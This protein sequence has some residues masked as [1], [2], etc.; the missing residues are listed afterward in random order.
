MHPCFEPIP[1]MTD[2]R[3]I[4]ARITLTEGSQEEP[5]TAPIL[6]N[7]A[8]NEFPP[9]PLTGGRRHYMSS[10]KMAGVMW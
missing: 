8:Q 3:A 10:A 2:W 4:G 6:E 7:A 1:H 5:K 9:R